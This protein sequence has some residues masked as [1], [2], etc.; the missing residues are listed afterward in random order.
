MKL[1][2]MVM[3]LLLTLM[4]MVILNPDGSDDDNS[5]SLTPQSFLL[6][7]RQ[8]PGHQLDPQLLDSREPLGESYSLSVQK[9]QASSSLMVL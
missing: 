2:M 1:M 4:V 8:L 3:A 7:G 9:L 6:Q 5:V